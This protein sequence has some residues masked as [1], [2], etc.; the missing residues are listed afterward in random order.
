MDRVFVDMDGVVVDFDAYRDSHHQTTDE[1]KHLPGAYLE[2][3]PIP[4]AI[5]AI[6]KVVAMGFD[7]WLATKP[8]TGVAT[9]YSEK[10]AWVFK[11]LPELKRKLIITH[12]KGLLGDIA[13]FL[14]DD[15]PG[16]ANCEKFS[17]TLIRFTDGYHWPQALEYLA[18]R[19]PINRSGV[20]ALVG[21]GDHQQALHNLQA[22]TTA[23]AGLQAR[24]VQAEFGVGHRG[25]RAWSGVEVRLRNGDILT[26]LDMATCEDGILIDR[27]GAISPSVREILHAI[28]H[29]NAITAGN[30]RGDL[31]LLSEL[32]AVPLERVQDVIGAIWHAVH[33]LEGDPS[34]RSWPVTPETA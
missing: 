3:D 31:Q 20:T 10:A 28:E 23:I 13:D 6:R 27:E 12:D 33:S 1:V 17:G 25:K 22:M 15:R 34:E 29:A 32:F 24:I 16:K 7:V 19:S 30:E 5:E 18:K 21:V 11:H 9:A 2:M 26:I 8:P 4:G 14:L